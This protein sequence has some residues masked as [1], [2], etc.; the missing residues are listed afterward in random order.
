MATK[1]STREL[2]L[3]AAHKIL[4]TSGIRCLTQPAVAKLIGI[5][6]GQLT[7]HFQ[8]RDD[9]MLGLTTFAVDKIAD[10]LWNNQ[11]SIHSR[12]F[13]KLLDLIL[14][15]MRSNSHTRTLIGLIVEADENPE[16]RTKM[17]D[18]ALK[19][20]NLIAAGLQVE[21][22]DPVVSISHAQIIGF[23][24][25]LFMQ[26]DKKQRKKLEEEFKISVQVLT[27]HLR[28]RN[29]TTARVRNETTANERKKN[30]KE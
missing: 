16:V 11:A 20:R 24:I 18:L 12:S 22:D 10:F 17:L 30:T 26:T 6:Q 21:D 5:S 15:Y 3:E 19:V 8:K 7:Y 29:E 4:E 28:V 13:S 1:K 9:L 25:M 2:I 14:I 27:E 23:S